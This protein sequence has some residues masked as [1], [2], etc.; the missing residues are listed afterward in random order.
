MFAPSTALE[1][2]HSKIESAF[3]K[4]ILR[5][6]KSTY[7]FSD[8]KGFETPHRSS[9]RRL[10]L[11]LVAMLCKVFSISTR[12]YTRIRL[13]FRGRVPLFMPIYFS[14]FFL[15]KFPTSVENPLSA[16]FRSLYYAADTAKN[17]Y[18]ARHPSHLT[19]AF[20]YSTGCPEIS[21]FSW[22][23]YLKANLPFVR[24]ITAL[25]VCKLLRTY[26]NLYSEDDCIIKR[27]LTLQSWA[28]L[29][30]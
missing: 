22:W 20:L 25:D 9:L 29:S 30:Q 23:N 28:I 15:R 8:F 1:Y 17:E 19:S 4:F 16:F 26:L 7:M 12:T 5:T 24:P 3:N 10:L 14:S 6:S 27:T 13:R 18:L 21:V 11:L 2:E